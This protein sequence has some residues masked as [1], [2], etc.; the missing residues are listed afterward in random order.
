M[1]ASTLVTF[2]LASTLLIAVPGPSVLFIIG[3]AL[4]MGRLV[5]VMTALGNAG[6]VVVLAAVVALGLGPILQRS[7]ALLLAV[8]LAGAAY[9]IVLGLRALLLASPHRAQAPPVRQD[10]RPGWPV[11]LREGFVVGVLNPKA[12]VFFSAVLPQFVDP[13]AGALPAQIAVLGL[14]MV[15]IGLV[16]DTGWAL[17]AG[18]ARAWFATDERRNARTT[19]AGGVVMTGLGAGLAVEALRT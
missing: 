2:A 13:G 15:S 11:V 7:E 16:L 17:F 8:K 12:L 19:A 10:A 3:R 5:A 6:G 4:A 1:T 18:S 14:V 9:L